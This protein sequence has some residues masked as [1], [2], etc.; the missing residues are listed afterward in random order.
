MILQIKSPDLF[1]LKPRPDRPGKNKTQTRGENLDRV[2][3]KTHPHRCGKKKT[4]LER[5][6]RT[7]KKKSQT[8]TGPDWN[9]PGS[10]YV[11][12]LATLR[13]R[14]HAF[15]MGASDAVAGI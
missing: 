5:T 3:F 2:V 9:I 8:W 13:V 14:A 11:R 15:S 4:G 7:D 10:L 6:T 12:S 1:F